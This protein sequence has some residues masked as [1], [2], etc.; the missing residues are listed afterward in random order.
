[1]LCPCQSSIE[2][3]VGQIWLRRVDVMYVDLLYF[4]SPFLRPVVNL[5]DRGLSFI[6]AIAG[7]S[8][9]AN[10]AVS[11]AKVTVVLSDVGS[12]LVS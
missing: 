10:I 7:S 2:M 9:V 6:E 4:N 11:S 5:T 8:C 3:Y 12:S 1:M